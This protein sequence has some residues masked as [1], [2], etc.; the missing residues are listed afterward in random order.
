MRRVFQFDGA[1]G[2]TLTL[3]ECTGEASVKIGIQKDGTAAEL[4]LSRA[5]F[6]ELSGLRFTLSFPKEECRTAPE[7]AA[8]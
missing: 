1:D 3:G 7:R 6:F 8:A 2:G 4:T 5:D